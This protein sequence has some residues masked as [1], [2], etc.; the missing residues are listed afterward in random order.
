MRILLK[1]SDELIHEGWVKDHLGNYINLDLEPNVGYFNYYFTGLLGKELK[2]I[3]YL[4]DFY[5]CEPTFMETAFH[6]PKAIVKD[7]V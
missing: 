3:D 5:I 4:H 7:V 2:V 6:V 1:T